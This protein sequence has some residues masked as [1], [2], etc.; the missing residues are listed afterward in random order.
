MGLLE[1]VHYKRTTHSWEQLGGTIQC[2]TK[3]KDAEFD[4]QFPTTFSQIF[5]HAKTCINA[6]LRIHGWIC[7]NYSQNHSLFIVRYDNRN[8]ECSV[9]FAK[10]HHT[11]KFNSTAWSLLIF[12]NPSNLSL[13]LIHVH[14]DSLAA[15]D[16]L[17]ID[18]RLHHCDDLCDH[19]GNEISDNHITF[20]KPSLM[21]Q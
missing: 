4:K 12:A 11:R 13:N 9:C 6:A 21:I 20:L 2:D 10:L 5:V 1:L 7:S 14:V 18:D 17:S 15:P 8:V 16:H 3:L 19:W